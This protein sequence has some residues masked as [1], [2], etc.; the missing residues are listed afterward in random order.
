MNWI[1]N[2]KLFTLL[3][4]VIFIIAL[5]FLFFGLWNVSLLAQ[6]SQKLIIVNYIYL[7]I[8]LLAG[9]F[10]FFLAMKNNTMASSFSNQLAE[11]EKRK[12]KEKKAREQAEKTKEERQQEE[13]DERVRELLPSDKTEKLEEYSEELL[14]RISKEYEIV[15]GLVHVKKSG[16]EIFTVFGKYAFYSEEPPADFKLGETIPGQAAKD[17]QL[18]NISGIPEKYF[19]VLSG[20]GKAAPTQM[21][22]VPVVYNGETIAVLELAAF[23]AFNQKDE[24]FFNSFAKEISGTFAKLTQK[25]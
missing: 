21:L 4:L 15:V 18:I 11:I 19:E 10:L 25:A 6:E 16:D 20:L 8:I 22:V 24:M 12:R 23:K 1:K 9:G 7:I 13:I 3:A 2:S 5:A 17:K 14:K